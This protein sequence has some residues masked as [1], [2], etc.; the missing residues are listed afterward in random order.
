MSAHNQQNIKQ[1]KITAMLISLVI[2]AVSVA[3]AFYVANSQKQVLQ[4]ILAGHG[5]RTKVK[6]VDNVKD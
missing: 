5:D 2:L 4:Q 6:L 1:S 3:V